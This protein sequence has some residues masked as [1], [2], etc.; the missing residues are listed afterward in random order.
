M[1]HDHAHGHAHEPGHAHVHAP[2]S[3]GKAF[4]VGAG[5][6]FGFVIV[7]AFY[8]AVSHSVA[9]VAD[10]AHNLGDVLGLLA[11]W[12]AFALAKRRPTAKRTYG[13]RKS[14]V[15]AALANAVLLLVAV[16]GVAWESIGKLRDPQPI[17][18]G[19]VMV[20]AAVGV[21]VNGCSALLF[22][23][24]GKTDA[25]MRGVFLH[26][27]A[28]A[29]VSLAVVVSGAVISYTS[30]LWLDP[31][32]SLVV[33]LIILVATWKLL[34]KSVNLA[35]DAVPEHVDAAALLRH[36]NALPGV[37]EVHDFHVWAMST[38]ESAMTAHLVLQDAAHPA[39]FLA[40]LGRD[41][42]ARFGVDHTTVQIEPAS[43]A[44]ECMLCPEGA[45]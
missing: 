27:A 34:V 12:A 43:S 21:V 42:H 20:V 10:A 7:E 11:A 13:L 44:H 39:P 3:Y 5:L 32:V 14:T 25:N 37:T 6:N 19:T 18:T 23:R 24:G 45:L 40:D 26:L 36:L 2:A 30:W 4:A 1:G 8:G 22:A 31:A 17:Q 41:L 33:S 15:L 29:L 16:G 35:L 38:T 28:D 9:L